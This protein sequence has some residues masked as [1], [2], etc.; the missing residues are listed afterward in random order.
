MAPYLPKMSY[1]S[2]GVISKGKF[3]EDKHERER[4]REREPLNSEGKT[5]SVTR[6]SQTVLHVHREIF[7]TE[8]GVE[9]FGAKQNRERRLYAHNRVKI[10]KGEGY[11]IPKGGYPPSHFQHAVSF[12]DFFFHLQSGNETTLQIHV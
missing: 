8:R 3:L 5:T 7:Y 11:K 2:S 1:I 4:E 10:H 6:A 9:G 12:P